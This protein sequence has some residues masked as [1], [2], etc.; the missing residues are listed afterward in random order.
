MAI[1]CAP[2]TPYRRGALVA[3]PVGEPHTEPVRGV[4]QGRIGATYTDGA[5]MQLP[6]VG[7]PAL[8]RLEWQLDGSV[9]F[10]ASDLVAI[11]FH[12]AYGHVSWA[13]Q[14]AVQTPPVVDDSL[15]LLGASGTVGGTV[16]QHQKVYVG[17]VL[18]LSFS[19][20]PWSTWERLSGGPDDPTTWAAGTTFDE[21]AYRLLDH[22][23]ELLFLTRLSFLV[24]YEPDPIVALHGGLSVQNHARN[25]G[26]DDVVRDG[27]TLTADDWGLVPFVGLTVRPDPAF[28]LQAQYFY[29]ALYEQ[30][31]N[32]WERTFGGFV[33]GIGGDFGVRTPAPR[34]ASPLVPPPKF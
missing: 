30:M 17:G 23:T 12:G 19:G 1:G 33:L 3:A 11:G 13:Q 10:A 4:A 25:I 14:S 21:S 6:Q 20:M 26:F 9:R 28:Y 7:D 2:Q 27:S 16:D 29:P 5:T 32:S 31:R 22:G 34:P 24:R 8:W 15:W 18:A